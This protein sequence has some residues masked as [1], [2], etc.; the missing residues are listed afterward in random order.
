MCGE[1]KENPPTMHRHTRLT[2]V[3]VKLAAKPNTP[4][5]CIEIIFFNKIEF[6]NWRLFALTDQFSRSRVTLTGI[7]GT[8]FA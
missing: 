3:L 5:V 1:Q 4:G 2:L 7:A 6:I 8:E